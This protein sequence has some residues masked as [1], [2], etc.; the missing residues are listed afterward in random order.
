MKVSIDRGL[1]GVGTFPG[2]IH[3]YVAHTHKISVR[4]IVNRVPVP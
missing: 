2:T 1:R 4:S 3:P